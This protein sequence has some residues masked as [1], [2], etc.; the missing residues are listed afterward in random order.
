MSIAKA[1]PLVVATP[2]AEGVSLRY[3]LHP[4]QGKAFTSTKR[5]VLI[6]AGAR[7][8]KTSFGPIWLYHEMLAKGPGDYLVAGPTYPILDKAAAPEIE[9]FFARTLHYGSLK[10]SPLRFDFSL[11]GCKALWPGQ[12]I[13]RKPRIVFG[14]ADDPESLEAM[15]V[16]AAWLD[17]AGQKRFRLSSYEAIQRRLTIDQGRC[18]LT[19][20]PYD[21][22]W[23]KQRLHDPWLA[24]HRQHP[25]IDVITFDSTM[26]P[27]FP[28]EEFDRARRELPL[29][30][31]LMFFR[32]QFSRPAGLIHD[33][34]DPHR[35]VVARFAIPGAWPRFVGVDFGATNTAAIYLAEEQ[36]A[37]R[38]PTGRFFVY[39]EYHPGKLPPETHAVRLLEG[40]PR[41]PTFVGGNPNEQAWRDRF[42]AAGIGMAEPP[43]KEVEVGIDA[44]YSLFA[45]DRLLIMD[46]LVELLD[47]LQSYSRKLDDA[48][49]PTEDIDSPNLYHLLDALRYIGVWL[50][51]GGQT[52]K[53]EA[54]EPKE[55]S[56][57]RAPEG[58]WHD[59]E[60]WRAEDENE[61]ELIRWE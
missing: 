9:A 16:K 51:R 35:H 44:V 60:R 17:E 3:N 15:T 36:D 41:Q 38:L 47:E 54:E 7:G 31:F 10:R 46:D 37:N 20:T 21:L 25:E 13:E 24:M 59:E 61:E 57:H 34:F 8:G 45:Q 50:T 5:V 53:V 14:H 4:G 23:L 27:A 52:W 40:E 39:R 56:I 32:G 1:S 29:W 12:K 2:S 42:A 18:L 28:L 43:V 6:L 55:G 19:T 30:K 26:N 58:V 11:S 33:R 48:G 22:G 49:E